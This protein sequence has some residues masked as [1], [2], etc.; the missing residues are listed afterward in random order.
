M[1][2]QIFPSKIVE[3]KVTHRPNKWKIGINS[4]TV[5]R[6]RIKLAFGKV[7]YGWWFEV[8]ATYSARY[9]LIEKVE[10]IWLL[11]DRFSHF[12]WPHLWLWHYFMQLNKS[13][14]SLNLYAQETLKVLKTK[15]RFFFSATL[16]KEQTYQIS[17]YFPNR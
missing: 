15:G 16:A 4:I 2:C 17:D 5:M 10:N 1:W 12:G 14:L 11:H 6:I 13:Q 7:L 9:N 3:V 8:S